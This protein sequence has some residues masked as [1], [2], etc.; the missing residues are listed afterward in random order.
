MLESVVAVLIGSYA[1]DLATWRSD[2]D[3]LVLYPGHRPPRVKVPPGVHVYY[4]NKEKFA[5][6]FYEGDDYAVSSARYG[7][8]LHDKSN[9]WKT[10]Q[11]NLES[12][13]WPDWIEKLGHAE[14]RIKMGDQLLDGD[15]L[16]A[17]AEEYLLAATQIARA[18]LLMH[19]I[20]PL[21]R[22]EISDQ[23]IE[24]GHHRLAADVQSLIEGRAVREELQRIS[25]DLKMALKL[26][27]N[28]VSE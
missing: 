16:D 14:R 6:R 10:L 17:A 19:H 25:R 27:E 13:K 20:Y 15:D 18:I 26:Q 5:N 23:L 1:R 9:F 7:K 2:V 12:V 3:I 24:V 22:P 28:Q 11:E 8:L 21:S 4:E